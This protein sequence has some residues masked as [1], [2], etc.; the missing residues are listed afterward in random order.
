MK[1]TYYSNAKW[2]DDS[3][4]HDSY[5]EPESQD[6]HSTEREALSVCKMLERD[7]LGG[8]GKIFP[9]RTWVSEKCESE[10]AGWC[11]FK[12]DCDYKLPCDDGTAGCEGAL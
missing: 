4:V 11:N 6:R 3:G 10:N 5:G 1:H 9:V 12:G 2:P 8:E 7:G